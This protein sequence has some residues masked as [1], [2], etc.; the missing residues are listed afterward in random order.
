MFLA[1]TEPVEVWLKNSHTVPSTM[2]V[3]VRIIY[4]KLTP[5][6][7]RECP[8][9]HYVLSPKRSAFFIDKKNL[10]FY[11]FPMWLKNIHIVPSPIG[12]GVRII[13][14]K[15]TPT[16]HPE[17]PPQP[18]V[19]SPKRS[20]F[21]IDKKNLCFYVSMFLACTEPVEVWL[22]NIHIVPSPVGVEVRLT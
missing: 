6:C 18:Y 5:T 14:T 4:T 8:P 2:G 16:C 17:C 19:L 13:G 1:C 11:V 3:E 22:K 7:H 15:L 20:A 21:F 10:C 9:Q 12:A